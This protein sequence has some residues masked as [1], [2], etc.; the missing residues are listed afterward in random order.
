V[1]DDHVAERA[2]LLE[3]S[4]AAL[5]RQLLGHV[6]LDI[7]DVPAVPDRFEQAVG[8]AKRE[9][10]L[11]GLLAEEMVD[12][13]DLGLVE[14]GVQALVERARRGQVVTEGL[15]DDQPGPFAET[16]AEHRPHRPEGVGRH[17]QVDQ[18]RQ[19][20]SKLLLGPGHCLHEGVGLIGGGRR[21]GQALCEQ[22]PVLLGELLAAKLAKSLLN[23]RAKALGVRRAVGAPGANDPEVLGH[24]SRHGEVKQ[25][26]QQFA[27]GQVAGRPEQNQHLVSRAR[28]RQRERISRGGGR[29]HL[30]RGVPRALRTRGG[31]RRRWRTRRSSAGS[32][33]RSA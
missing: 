1:G 31:S 3:E 25:A 9:D 32:W 11:H 10:V 33:R 26:G 28:R 19:I 18:P 14:H 12:P 13:E 23:M 7:V 17:R 27:L 15:L 4:G 29:G 21:E 5:D 24:H 22:R 8:E 16:G 6:D 30:T 20:A 2:G